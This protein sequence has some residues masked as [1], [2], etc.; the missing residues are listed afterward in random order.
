MTAVQ[1]NDKDGIHDMSMHRS[2]VYRISESG[3]SW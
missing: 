2:A 3:G 1:G